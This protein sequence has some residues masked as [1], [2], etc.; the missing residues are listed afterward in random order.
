MTTVT[1]VFLPGGSTSDGDWGTPSVAN[2]NGGRSMTVVGGSSRSVSIRFW[3]YAGYPSGPIEPRNQIGNQIP[4]TV[5]DGCVEFNYTGTGYSILDTVE[6]IRGP[7]IQ[8]PQ[9]QIDWTK[10]YLFVE[11]TFTTIGSGGVSSYTGNNREQWVSLAAT[12]DLSWGISGTANGAN[13]PVYAWSFNVY[14]IESATSLTGN[15][16]RA[17]GGEVLLTKVAHQIFNLDAP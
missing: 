17:Q 13:N 16:T 7:W 1:T 8:H 14:A 15:T 4:H 10:I 3:G 11:S 12:S 6:A 5:M 9:G 2:T